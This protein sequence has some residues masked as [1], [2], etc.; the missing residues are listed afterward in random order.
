MPPAPWV[1][2]LKA[3]RPRLSRDLLIVVWWCAEEESRRE[4]W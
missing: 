4:Q 3:Q 2:M 1:V